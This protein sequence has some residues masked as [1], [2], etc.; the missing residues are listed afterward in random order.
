MT[1]DEEM[2]MAALMGTVTHE[3]IRPMGASL[4]DA[5]AAVRAAQSL[6][7]AIYRQA[8]G[9]AALL[10]MV[11]GADPEQCTPR[12]IGHAL[13][14]ILRPVELDRLELSADAPVLSPPGLLELVLANLISNAKSYA[15]G[16]GLTV[17]SCIVAPQQASFPEEAEV[18]YT[19]KVVLLTVSDSGPGIPSALRPMLFERLA[20]RRGNPKGGLGLWL[21]RMLLRAT[22]GDIWLESPPP[23][24]G[25]GT[26]ITSAWPLAFN[27][28]PDGW[29]QDPLLFGRQVRQLRERAELTRLQFSAIAKI[30]DST[31]R[32]VEHGR[33]KMNSATRRKLIDAF[34]QL[35]LVRDQER[36]PWDR[37]L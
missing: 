22:G 5:R 17:S 9:A 15:D 24:A 25:T 29:P 10:W 30:A 31:I 19:G 21:C 20:W 33:H 18:T 4:L 11:N 14:A 35:G 8:N 7:R 6:E 34:H 23:G 32:N 2:T 1:D 37:D 36:R 13:R 3:M 12:Y 26:R 27:T 16:A 28:V